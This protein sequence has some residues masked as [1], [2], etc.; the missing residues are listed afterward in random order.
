MK[1]LRGWEFDEMEEKSSPTE[2]RISFYDD[3]MQVFFN[4]PPFLFY[5]FHNQRS[6]KPSFYPCP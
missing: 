1:L 5:L 6:F 3:V 2:K 4:Q